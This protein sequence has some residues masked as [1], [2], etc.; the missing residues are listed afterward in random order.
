MSALSIWGKRTPRE[1]L[2][3]VLGLVV[4]AVAGYLI[5]SPQEGA[6]AGMLSSATA[7]SRYD[8]A[9]QQKR[10]AD[11]K[12]AALKP[13]VDTATYNQ[14]SE[15]VMPDVLKTLS[16]DAGLAGVHLREVKPLRPRSVGGLT[17]VTL[18]VRFTSEFGRVIPFVYHVED[19]Q[20]KLVVEK[21]NVSSPDPKSR[22][23]DV[24]VQVALF[25]AAGS[26]TQEGSNA[27]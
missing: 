22:Q 16:D 5:F 24:E 6:K 9:M 20:G 1:R 14:T 27:I 18:T 4:V 15:R 12:I 11:G 3:L 26:G 17:K 25:T 2:L 19:P 23:V 8:A 13:K 21:L 7:R 10:D